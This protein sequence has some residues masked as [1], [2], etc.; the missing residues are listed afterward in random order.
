[1]INGIPINGI[2]STGAESKLVSSKPVELSVDLRRCE[3][4]NASDPGSL[5]AVLQGGGELSSDCDEQLLITVAFTTPVKLFSISVKAPAN[6]P[7]ELHLFS[8]RTSM[9]FEDAEGMP[10]TQ[11]I[12]LTSTHVAGTPV[13]VQYVKFQNV[14][15]LSIFIPSN[16]EETDVTTLHQLRFDGHP[17][18]TTNMSE[19]K[20][21]G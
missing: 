21:M 10:P 11:T 14:S 16:Q 9:A 1:M 2:Q 19:L 18:A 7:S 5:A 12:A 4:L 13:P 20:K 6:A 15:T 8:N 17:I 3:V